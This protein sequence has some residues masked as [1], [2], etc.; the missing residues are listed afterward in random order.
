MKRSI[1]LLIF[2]C[3]F[4]SNLSAQCNVSYAHDFVLMSDLEKRGLVGN[5]DTVIYSHYNVINKF[6]DISKGIKSCEQL[7][8]FNIDGSVNKIVNYNSEGEIQDVDIHEYENGQIK[9]ISSFNNT[10]NLL[11]KTAFIKEGKN[12]REQR[13][14]ADGSK[15]DQYFVRN[16]DVNERIV[17][18]EWK[19]HKEEKWDSKNIEQFFYDSNNRLYKSVTNNNKTCTY[20]YKNTQSKIPIKVECIYIDNKSNEVVKTKLIEFDSQFNILKK[21]VR[22]KLLYSYKYFYDN[23]NNWIQR[24]EFESEAMIPTE[25]LERQIIYLK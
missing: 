6:G 10:G 22:N 19:Y 1:K 13:Y 12:I 3:S 4:K 9:L 20:S 11:A 16:Y 18:E 21:Y 7:I 8:I 14:L 17:K 23:R 15:N 24:I 5:V 2:I 25:I